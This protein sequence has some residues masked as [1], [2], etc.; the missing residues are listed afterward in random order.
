LILV[1]Y[2]IYYSTRSDD[3]AEKNRQAYNT[4]TNIQRN[5][6]DPQ[7]ELVKEYPEGYFLYTSMTQDAAFV[8]PAPEKFDATKREQEEVYNSIRIFRLLKIFFLPA[9]M[10]SQEIMFGSI[11]F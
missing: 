4:L 1:I 2:N 3:D 10:I 6:L 7:N 11:I 9:I 8:E 5:W